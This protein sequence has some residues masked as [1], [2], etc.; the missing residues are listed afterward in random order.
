MPLKGRYK[1]SELGLIPEDWKCERLGRFGDV[2]MCKRIF[3]EQ[4]KD[5]GEI[6]FYKIGTFGSQA[7]A[8]I[9]RNLFNEYSKKY[10]FPKLGD[11]LISAAG[12]IGRTVRYDGIPAYFQ[13]SNIVWIENDQTQITN[14]YLGHFYKVTKWAKS[15]G[16][17]VARLYNNNLKN[18]IYIAFPSTQDEQK[19]ISTTLS[20]IDNLI[21]SLDKLIKKKSNIK[22]AILQE[23]MTCKSRLKGYSARWDIKPLGDIVNVQKGQLLTSATLHPGDIPVIAGEK[24]AAYYHNKANRFGKTITISASGANA[25]YVSFHSKP[26]FASDCSTISDSDT[27]SI[28]FIYYQL[29]LKQQIIYDSQTGGAQSHIHPKDLNPININLPKID[30]QREIA[31]VITDIESEIRALETQLAKINLIKLGMMR[32]LLFGTIRII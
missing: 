5:I 27:Y 15:D 17:A 20:D 31:K 19:V 25:G 26:I 16:G 29:H 30:E 14:D 11:I 22:T 18:K 7:D 21:S 2:K 3:K 12:T 28:E 32:K 6:P 24:E 13:D 9:T 4:T 8:F 23:L 1:N 10:S